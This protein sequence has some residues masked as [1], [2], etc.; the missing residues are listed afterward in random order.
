MKIKIVSDGTT[1]NTHVI[2]IETGDELEGVTH[3]DWH[4][5]AGDLARCTIKLHMIPLEIEAD[6]IKS[7]KLSNEDENSS[8]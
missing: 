4:L 3:I 1:R 6:E 2:D 7:Y 8:S 5:E